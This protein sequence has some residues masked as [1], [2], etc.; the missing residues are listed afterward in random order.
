MKCVG[1]VL[2]LFIE[3]AFA[4]GHQQLIFCG[5]PTVPSEAINV[6]T[7]PLICALGTGVPLV[8]PLEELKGDVWNKGHGEGGQRGWRMDGVD[9]GWR[10]RESKKARRRHPR[11]DASKSLCR[12]QGSA[13]LEPDALGHFAKHKLRDAAEPH[14]VK[15]LVVFVGVVGSVAVGVGS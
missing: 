7:D 15:T 9:W 5:E 1:A 6:F 14:A 4:L 12:M 11:R 3:Q 13:D 10:K 8:T 2:I